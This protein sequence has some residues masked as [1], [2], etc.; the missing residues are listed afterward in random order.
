MSDS[1][2][3]TWRLSKRG[4]Q[5]G[6]LRMEQWSASPF[7]PVFV[8]QPCL[9]QLFFSLLTRFYLSITWQI[10]CRDSWEPA[11]WGEKG[12][13]LD[14]AV[15]QWSLTDRGDEL[16]NPV[17]ARAPGSWL[18]LKCQFV[19]NKCDY[20][21]D[22]GDPRGEED[23]TRAECVPIEWIRWCLRLLDDWIGLK[24]VWQYLWSLP[25]PALWRYSC[26]CK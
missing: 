21:T 8:S 18:Q 2:E 4:A 3:K 11:K 14:M 12:I 5:D 19:I 24:C 6:L 10:S 20:S 16:V 25:R 1:K 13:V 7:P 26:N 22:T 15:L 17:I 9:W 23:V